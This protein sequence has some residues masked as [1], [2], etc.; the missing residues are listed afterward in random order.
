MDICIGC[1]TRRIP[2][3]YLV[4]A[5][6]ELPAFDTWIE[7]RSIASPEEVTARYVRGIPGRAGKHR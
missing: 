6:D 4:T 7:P 1:L 3:F 2:R 5:G